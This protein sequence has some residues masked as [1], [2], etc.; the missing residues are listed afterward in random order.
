MSKENVYGFV[1]IDNNKTIYCIYNA[2]ENI[3]KIIHKIHNL[4][5]T[6]FG[7]EGHTILRFER[8]RTEKRYRIGDSLKRV[9]KYI[10]KIADPISDIFSEYKEIKDIIIASTKDFIPILNEYFNKVDR[11]PGIYSII[12]ITCG[13]ENGFEQAIEHLEK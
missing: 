13:G 1:I 7:E 11:S 6:R 4:P 2:C 3:R 8:L 12:S 5:T 9:S 10:K